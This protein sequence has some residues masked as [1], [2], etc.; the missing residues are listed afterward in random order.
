MTIVL[1]RWQNTDEKA[2]SAEIEVQKNSY[3]FDLV[4]SEMINDGPMARTLF[5]GSYRTKSSA[6]RAMKNQGNFTKVWDLK[7]GK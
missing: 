3:C 1:E 6:R 4:I 7:G 5:Q 2:V